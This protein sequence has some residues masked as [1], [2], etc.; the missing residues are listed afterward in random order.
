MFMFMKLNSTLR[1]LLLISSSALIIS[2][3]GD[4]DVGELKIKNAVTSNRSVVLDTDKKIYSTNDYVVD[5]CKRV[6]SFSETEGHE[7]NKTFPTLK[8]NVIDIKL[9]SLPVQILYSDSL[10]FGNYG[11]E[12]ILSISGNDLRITDVGLDAYFQNE[13]DFYHNKKLTSFNFWHSDT[14]SSKEKNLIARSD[15]VNLIYNLQN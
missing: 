7:L 14:Y 8:N 13:G 6:V 12:D 3:C 4:N 15:Y 2:S 1:N 11:S 9:Y 5:F 10:P